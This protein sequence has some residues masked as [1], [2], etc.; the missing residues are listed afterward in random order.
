MDQTMPNKPQLHRTFAHAFNFPAILDFAAI[1]LAA[2]LLA[3]VTAPGALAQPQSNDHEQTQEA[4]GAQDP[5]ATGNARATGG[6]AANGASAG[7][8][9]PVEESSIMSD[10]TTWLIQSIRRASSREILAAVNAGAVITEEAV[11]LS[12]IYTDGPTLAFFLQRLGLSPLGTYTI[13]VQPRERQ[14]KSNVGLAMRRR[15]MMLMSSGKQQTNN[16]REVNLLHLAALVGN[17]DTARYLLEEGVDPNAK[18]DNGMTPLLV[19]YNSWIRIWNPMHV[20]DSAFTTLTR[21]TN[22][23]GF[24]YALLDGGASVQPLED[25]VEERR[26]TMER[27]VVGLAENFDVPMKGGGFMALGEL[28]ESICT[29]TA[30]GL[31]DLDLFPK[32]SPHYCRMVVVFLGKLKSDGSSL[33]IPFAF[34]DDRFVLPGDLSLAE[35]LNI[36]HAGTTFTRRENLEFLDSLGVDL[37]NEAYWEKM[38]SRF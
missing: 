14:D 38:D 8:V 37:S 5:A 34:L 13:G 36:W 11:W 6:N 21:N 9:I 2:C 23:P 4:S 16:L 35:D 10:P 26:D 32:N 12:A 30:W 27:Y 25:L 18:A 19:A 33:A 22:Y 31:V 24:I 20:A 3:C 17:T 15:I 28:L 29:N 1:F 7:N